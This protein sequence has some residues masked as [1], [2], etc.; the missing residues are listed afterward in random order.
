MSVRRDNVTIS[1]GRFNLLEMSPIALT[2]F[3]YFK[4]YPKEREWER[5]H[6]FALYAMIDSNPS[7]F[8]IT[9]NVNMGGKNMHTHTP[10]EFQ[11]VKISSNV[12]QVTRL[13]NKLRVS[14]HFIVMWRTSSYDLQC[15]MS[16]LN[17]L[18]RSANLLIWCEWKKNLH[19]ER[20]F[21]LM[22]QVFVMC[23]FVRQPGWHNLV[24]LRLSSNHVYKLKWK[25]S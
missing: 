1:C 21:L 20:R 19:D 8:S 22:G 17:S 5:V 4:I 10:E 23:W 24:D 14:S 15:I 7:A 18:L 6:C 9:L 25:E 3:R 2:K 12:P 16:K 13:T 11:L